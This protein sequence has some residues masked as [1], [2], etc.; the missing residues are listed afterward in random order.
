MEQIFANVCEAGT[1]AERGERYTQ[2]EKHKVTK[3]GNEWEL[4]TTM[5]ITHLRFQKTELG[6]I[7]VFH[8]EISSDL[9]TCTD[10]HV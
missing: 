7:Q 3:I 8:K 9:C 4:I 5:K 2:G 6:Y 10:S 1:G